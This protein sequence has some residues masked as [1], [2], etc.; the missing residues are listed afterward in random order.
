ME[1][2]TFLSLPAVVACA[3]RNTVLPEWLNRQ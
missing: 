2:T 3:R 1:V